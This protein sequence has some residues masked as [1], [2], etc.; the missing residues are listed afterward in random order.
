M[1]ID[2]EM[3]K[4]VR[5]ESADVSVATRGCP[6]TA[7]EINDAVDQIIGEDDS[8][9][10]KTPLFA[11]AFGFTLPEQPTDSDVRKMQNFIRRL[12]RRTLKYNI[13]PGKEWTRI[14][15]LTEEQSKE[16]AQK[17]EDAKQHLAELKE[18]KTNTAQ[19]RKTKKGPKK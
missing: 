9:A 3:L 12:H 7:K 2:T 13:N 5:E 15:K 6:F 18:R 1:E 8:I 4:K 14:Y 11:Q 10:V 16:K 19:S 17:L